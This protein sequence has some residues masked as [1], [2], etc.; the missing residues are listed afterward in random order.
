[1]AKTKQNKKLTPYEEELLKAAKKVKEYKL[2]CE[3]NIVSI[4]YKQPDLMYDYQLKLEDFSENTWRVYWQ[5]AYDIIIKEKKSSLD[6]ITVGLYLEKHSKLK[7]K[8]DEYGGYDTI[9]KTKEYVVID[10]INGYINEFNKWNTVLLLLKNKFPVFDKLSDFADMQI[11]DVY[12]QY[13]AMLNHIFIN[14]NN[15]VESYNGCE[16]LHEYIDNL[17]NGISVGMPFHNCDILNREIGGFNCQGNIYGLGANSGIGKST[18]AINYIIPSIIKYDEKVV[19]FINEEDQTKIQRELLIWVANNIFKNELHKYILRDGNFE[20]ETLQLLRKCADWLEEKKEKRNI[21][22]IPLEHY[23]A[24]IVIKLIKKYSSLGVKYF[25]LDTLKESCDSKTDEIYKSMTRDMVALYDV[26]KPSVKNVGL[27]VTYQLGK[28]SIKMRYLTNNEIG[29]G[30]SIVDVMSV[31]L[32]MRRPFDDEFEGDKRE[33]I[34]YRF[35][36]KNGKTKIPFKLKRDKHY[37]ITFIPKNRFGA[38]DAFQIISEY[39]LSTNTNKDLGIC[40]IAQDW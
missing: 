16:G 35:E 17:N 32:M 31:N 10:N 19:F 39:D 11:D 28:A 23:S 29:L 5:I 13:E 38:T 26:V 33:I 20:P 2:A 36:G 6:D 30:K 25:V 22:I 27:F 24:K 21:T 3:A 4:F 14:A 37:M 8:Y 1:M 9:D 40:T 7:Q 34:G 15:T 18:T 12:S